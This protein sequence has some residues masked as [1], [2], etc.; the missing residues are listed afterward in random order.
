M[1]SLFTRLALKVQVRFL[2]AI[3]IFMMTSVFTEAQNKPKQET[4]AFNEKCLK[5]HGQS[6]YK[7]LNQ[8]SS[9]Q[10]TKRITPKNC[11]TK[12]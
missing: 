11:V 4:I 8:K 6:K 10:L 3:F 7:Y 5:C 12:L 1:I 2:M 9:P